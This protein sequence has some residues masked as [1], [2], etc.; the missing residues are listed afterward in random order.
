MFT[1]DLIVD[2]CKDATYGTIYADPPWPC[3]GGGGTSKLSHMRTYRPYRTMSEKQLIELPV[4]EISSP[5]SVLI[6]WTTWM[7]LPF[8]LKLMEEWGF[9][10]ATGKPWI[11]TTSTGKFAYGPGTWFLHCSELLLI[12]RRGKPFGS[13]G[14]PRPATKG[15]ILEPRGAHSEKPESVRAWA[16]DNLPGPHLELFARKV[17]EGWTCWG[18]EV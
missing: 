10:Y 1:G 9:R 13:M 14:N 2:C 3:T 8:S 7:H 15:I 12:G 5:D 17:T 6:M 18:N 11:K 16:K 4:K